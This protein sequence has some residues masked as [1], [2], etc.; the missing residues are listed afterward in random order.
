MKTTA[1]IGLLILC[2]VYSAIAPSSHAQTSSYPNKPINLVVP[3]PPGGATDILARIMARGLGA[4]LG[5]PIVVENK[6][7]AGT[8]IGAQAVAQAPADGYTLLITGNTTFTINAALKSRLPYDPVNGFTA[9]GILGQGPLVMLANKNLPV[10]SVQDMVALAKS[11]PGKLG[12]GSF[13]IGTS[14]HFAGEMIKVMAGAPITHVPYRG[15]APAM[16]DLIGGQI[17]FTFDTTIAA[18][19]QIAAGNVKALAVTTKKRS[20][21]L[22]KV[23]T[24]AESGY[25]D[26]ELDIWVAIVAPKA[27]PPNLQ[28]QLVK[29]MQEAMND[30][31]IRAELEKTGLDIGYQSPAAYQARI[32]KELPMLRAYVH[33]AGIPIE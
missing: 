19:P 11:Q 3:Y 7:G 13:G 4:K 1:K 8:A 22:P 20:A 9:I 18:A 27:L 10:N 15:S 33:K 6:A 25:P 17:P 5:Q 28:Q 31:N 16:S 21:S 30:P 32:A 24:F 23:P 26:Y 2:G 14:A 12:F 29:A